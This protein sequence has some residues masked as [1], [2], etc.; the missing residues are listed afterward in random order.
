MNPYTDPYYTPLQK[1]S[2]KG[3]IYA[4]EM[5]MNRLASIPIPK[6]KYLYKLTYHRD[7][8]KYYYSDSVT[9]KD[10]MKHNNDS[11][12]TNVEYIGKVFPDD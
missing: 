9:I 10:F 1:I 3:D 2:A 8:Y 4:F 11:D 6:H 7:F 12:I 5:P